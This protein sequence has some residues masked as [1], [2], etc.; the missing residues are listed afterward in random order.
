MARIAGIGDKGASQEA[1]M[2]MS[3]ND[4]GN[5]VKEEIGKHSGLFL[6]EGIILII[7]GVLAI[8]APIIATLAVAIFLGWLFLFMGG[9]GIVSSFMAR[10]QPG[11]WWSLISAIVAIIAGALLVGWPLQGALSLTLVLV[12]FFILEGIAT[13]MYALDHRKELT[14]RWGWMMGSGVITLVLAAMIF[15]QLPSSATW[16]IGLL[17]GIDMVFGGAALVAIARAARKAA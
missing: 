2:T 11:F 8:L 15:L 13:I 3:A 14:S 9:V 4:L 5:K 7:L 12:A 17:V 1:I 10:Q 6:A 16:A